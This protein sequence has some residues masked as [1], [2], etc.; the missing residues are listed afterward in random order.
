MDF[1]YAPPPP[2]P[3]KKGNGINNRGNLG[4]KKPVMANKTLNTHRDETPVQKQD[5]D[6]GDLPTHL[7]NSTTDGTEGM[8]EEHVSEDEEIVLKQTLGEPKANSDQEPVFISGTN[9]T[10]ETEEDINKW[11][12]ER[13]KKWPSR[14]NVEAKEKIRQEQQQEPSAI[15]TKKRS[16]TS[17]DLQAA[18]KSK[19]V[20]KFYQNHRRCK[21]GNKCKNV[22]EGGSG[23]GSSS[24]SSNTKII[25]NMPVVIPQRFKNEMYVNE[26]DSNTHS[27]LFKMLVQKDHYEHEND[28]VLEFLQYLNEKKLIDHDVNI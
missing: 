14:S 26:K 15:N 12:E 25:N 4:K 6:V 18:K 23:A 16:G 28:T 13:K 27:L 21:F 20:C 11:I 5:Y 7:P 24:T 10:L 22:H 17:S 8:T 9:I 1:G 3:Q 19:N 2:A